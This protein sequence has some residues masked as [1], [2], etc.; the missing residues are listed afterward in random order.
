M[1]LE[2]MYVCQWPLTV[3]TSYHVQHVVINNYVIVIYVFEH[4]L[5]L[6]GQSEHMSGGR[7]KLIIV[8]KCQL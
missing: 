6:S 8:V 2:P 3:V 7:K 1:F 5:L 4:S